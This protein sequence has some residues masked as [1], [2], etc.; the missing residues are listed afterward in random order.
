MRSRQA[1]LQEVFAA[2]RELTRTYGRKGL[3]HVGLKH[4]AANISLELFRL[5]RIGD[6]EALRSVIELL[7]PGDA[8]LATRDYNGRSLVL[9]ATR[10]GHDEASLRKLPR[11]LHVT[12]P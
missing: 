1:A 8:V 12:P 6:A 11:G 4:E 5:A 2:G 10:E 7:P 9:T 3:E